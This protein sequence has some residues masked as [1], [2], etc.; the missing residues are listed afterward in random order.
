VNL[1]SEATFSRSSQA[2]YYDQNGVVKVASVDEAR[3]SHFHNSGTKVLLLEDSRVNSY[4][5]SEDFSNAAWLKSAVTVTANAIAGPDG[6]VTADRI[7]ETNVT[8]QFYVHQTLPALTNNTVS[9]VSVFA[10]AGERTWLLVVVVDKAG[11]DMRVWFD[12][13]NGVVGT[14][15]A[16]L[17]ATMQPLASGWYR[18]EITANALTGGSTPQVHIR[19][20]T[21]DNDTDT[22][23]GD[24]TKGLYLWGAQFE[25]DLV[26]V[27]SYISSGVAAGTR[28]SDKLRWPFTSVP[29]PLTVYVRFVERGTINVVSALILQIGDSGNSHPQLV[30]IRNPSLADYGAWWTNASAVARS[31]AVV[32]A[33]AI[34]DIV[35]LRFVVNADGSVQLSQSINGAA[36]VGGSISATLAGYPPTAWSGQ[37]L[38]LNGLNGSF[39]GLNGFQAVKLQHG[40]QTLAYMR[41]L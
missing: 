35:E 34:G 41:A 6:S 17:T 24:A 3:S 29:Q 21:A 13:T 15:N 10:K 18:I 32:A 22:H 19:L 4:L 38:H 20:A 8:S 25:K 5:W 1:L 37:I 36:E 11:N 9:S 14:K 26:N 33:P 28:D 40:L 23:V 31:T 2:R 7:V 39:V 27:S 16:N 30:I 12:L